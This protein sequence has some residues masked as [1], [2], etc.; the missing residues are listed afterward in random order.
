MTYSIFSLSHEI[1]TGF[2]RLEVDL[3]TDSSKYE[4]IHRFSPALINVTFQSCPFGFI[5]N[6]INSEGSVKFACKCNQFS[7]AI[8]M[9]SIDDKTITKRNGSWVG[10]FEEHLATSEHCHL[11]YC[12]PNVTV[13]YSTN[14]TLD[15]DRQCRYNR[16]GLLC[17]S[18]R[19]GFSL[20]L[21]SLECREKCSNWWLFLV[22]P[23]ALAG[24]FLVF[25]ITY[26][27]LT[28]TTGTVCGLIFYANVIQD[29]SILLL[30]EHPVPVLSRVLQI[31]IAWLNLDLGIPTCF[32][33]GMQ[34]FGKTVLQAV[35]PVYIWLISA[36][37][38]FLSNRYISITRLVGQN[39]VKVL[40]TLVLLSYSKGYDRH[41]EP[42]NY[43]CSYQYYVNP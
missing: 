26:L 31:F 29:Y 40:A 23:L 19:K 14:I 27:N 3:A 34:A 24:I 32:Y 17:G 4:Y 21:G 13:I 30:Q 6:K 20:I 25:I 5:N 37:I 22:I 2:L 7:N 15:Q 38:I 36:V 11:D 39:A 18:C 16:S 41:P 35:F 43:H 9:C 33:D 8:K 1:S 12:D 28:V 10:V 42:G